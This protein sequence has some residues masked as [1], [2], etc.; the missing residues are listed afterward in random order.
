MFSVDRS[1]KLSLVYSFK[2]APDGAEPVG[3]LAVDST[4]NVYGTTL[5]GG[6]SSTCPASGCGTVFKIDPAGKETVLYTFRM[7][8]GEA[9]YGGVV[10]GSGGSLY[11]TTSAGGT[12]LPCQP[13]GCGTVFRIDKT[14]KETVLYNF[15][16]G[17]DGAFPMGG[18]A[19]GRD[20]AL[21]GTAS[22]GGDFDSDSCIAA[23]CGT[24]FKL[25]P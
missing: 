18:L 23:G 16:Q 20:G 11:G 21:Y 22:L 13:A 3:G 19:V 1:G 9:P 2:G 4:G 12:G 25:T 17:S 24:V 8:D 14:G 7:R 5:V 10:I 15:Q 6:D